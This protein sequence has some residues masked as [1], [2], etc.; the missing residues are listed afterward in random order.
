MRE[1]VAQQAL[2]LRRLHRLEALI[3]RHLARQ[4][5]AVVRLELIGEIGLVEPDDAHRPRVVADDRL[6]AVAPA[7]PDD[8]GAPDV[9]E[10]RLLLVH[11]E[12]GHRTDAGEV[13]VAVREEVEEVAHAADVELRQLRRHRA[14]DAADHGHGRRQRVARLHFRRVRCVLSLHRLAFR[15][16]VEHGAQPALPRRRREPGV[17][18]RYAGRRT[19]QA[20]NVPVL[21]R[22]GE[23]AV[24]AAD[25]GAV[26]TAALQLELDNLAEAQ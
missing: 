22:D 8:D 17:A 3:Q 5:H 13:V 9:H 11:R 24:E 15:L 18:P 14:L 10:R 21:A 23:E 4:H 1:L 6:R 16:A 25:H 19:D 20:G 12:L 7:E 26:V 2:P